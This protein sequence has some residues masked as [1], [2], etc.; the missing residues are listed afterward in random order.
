MRWSR[1]PGGY[2]IP[3]YTTEEKAQIQAIR[4]QGADD[5]GTDY[6]DWQ[7]W[8][9]Q[10]AADVEIEALKKTFEGYDQR[11]Q[12]VDQAAADKEAAQARRDLQP[13]AP[14]IVTN[15]RN[16]DPDAAFS[17]PAYNGNA[18]GTQYDN[19]ADYYAAVDAWAADP[20]NPNN[21]PE[22]QPPSSA[23]PRVDF[24]SNVDPDGVQRRT[25]DQPTQPGV[26]QPPQVGPLPPLPPP[27]GGQPPP[28]GRFPPSIPIYPDAP[29]WPV[30][31]Y[32]QGIGGEGWNAQQAGS[33]DAFRAPERPMARPAVP[34]AH[35][36]KGGV[37][38]GV[39]GQ[40]MRAPELGGDLGFGGTTNQLNTPP[41]LPGK[42]GAI[43]NLYGQQTP[44]T[45]ISNQQALINILAGLNS[46]DG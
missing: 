46:E 11:Q 9:D 43:Q 37:N 38:P 5:A 34:P 31:P 14:A 12:M 21:V 35:S 1:L 33:F 26:N 44:P 41:L 40:P 20:G 4:D 6:A 8:G 7:R 3:V 45:D 25:A 27:V 30:T 39:Y 16:R 24:P 15:E 10:S 19:W 22:P 13:Y 17:V 32:G 2:L 18:T 42:G 28:G 23:P 29:D 36:G